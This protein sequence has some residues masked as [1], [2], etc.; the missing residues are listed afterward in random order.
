MFEAYQPGKP[1]C[2]AIWFSRSISSWGCGSLHHLWEVTMTTIPT[3]LP[4]RRSLSDQFPHIRHHEIHCKSPWSHSITSK[5]SVNTMKSPFFTVSA[6]VQSGLPGITTPASTPCCRSG[7]K[8]MRFW[9]PM[10]SA[11]RPKPSCWSP[12]RPR[13]VRRSNG[14]EN[15]KQDLSKLFP[16]GC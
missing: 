15:P 3:C 2:L 11:A 12:G 5:S 8:S 9:R 10:A 1:L 14:G 13:K 7:A 4:L 16:T 6:A